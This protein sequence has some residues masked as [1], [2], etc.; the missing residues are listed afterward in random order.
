MGNLRNGHVLLQQV[1]GDKPDRPTELHTRDNDKTLTRFEQSP[2]IRGHIENGDV[3]PSSP[4]G[5]E[6]R[7]KII[8]TDPGNEF[9]TPI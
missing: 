3:S 5:I 6:R 7:P 4:E 1:L 9:P 2:A 8:R